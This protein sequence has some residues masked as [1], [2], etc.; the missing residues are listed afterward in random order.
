M[1][2]M[3]AS[4]D[5]DDSTSPLL[6]SRTTPSAM[7]NLLASIDTDDSTVVALLRYYSNTCPF[8]STSAATASAS[9]MCNVLGFIDTDNIAVLPLLGSSSA[10]GPFPP[11]LGLPGLARKPMPVLL[12]KCRTSIIQHTAELKSR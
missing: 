11:A 1:D 8:A 10:A 2:S 4:L 6:G 3:R 7:E 12:F 5:T 9:A